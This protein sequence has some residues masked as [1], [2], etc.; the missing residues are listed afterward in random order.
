MGSSSR[1]DLS[2]KIRTITQWAG[3]SMNGCTEKASK[4][5][6]CIHDWFG[7]STLAKAV[8]VSLELADCGERNRVKVSSDDG[9]FL[10]RR[11]RFFWEGFLVE[12]PSPATPNLLVIP[13][14]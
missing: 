6:E 11:T 9:L 2:N 7:L 13:A 10:I 3:S 14:Q 5:L 8:L 12:S 1:P 4:Q